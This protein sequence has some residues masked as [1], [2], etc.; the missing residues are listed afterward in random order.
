[1]KELLINRHL[2]DGKLPFFTPW[3]PS[4]TPE[5]TPVGVEGRRWTIEDSLKTAKNE[6]GLDQND[7]H[8]WNG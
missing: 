7:T 1:M 6:F 4:S 3:C 8:S 2:A 5:E